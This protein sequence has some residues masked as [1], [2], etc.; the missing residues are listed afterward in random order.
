MAPSPDQALPLFAH[1]AQT[2]TDARL[3]V[4]SRVSYVGV[5]ALSPSAMPAKAVGDTD[6]LNG[7]SR[8]KRGCRRPPADF[9]AEVQVA[10]LFD[11]IDRLSSVPVDERMKSF[12]RTVD[13]LRISVTDRCNERCLYCRP[14]QYA[15]WNG[16]ADPLTD[17]ALRRIVRVAA[18]LGFRKFRLT[19]GEPLLRP[20]LVELVRAMSATPG[21][22]CI[23]I[24]TNGL[25]LPSLAG[26]LRAAGARTVNISLDALSPAV[27]RR[28]TGGPV[29]P[30]LEGIRAALAARFEFV[31]LNTVLMRGVNEPEL[32]PLIRFSSE[33]GVPLRLIELMPLTSRD[34]LSPANFLSIGEVMRCLR[35]REELIPVQ[36]ARLGHGPA[37]YYRLAKTGAVVGFIGAMTNRHFCD[38]CNKMRL[39][40]D[41]RLRPCL[42]HHEE[43]NLHEALADPNNDEPLRR[44]FQQAL[45]NKP[46]EHAFRDQYTPCRPM[47]AIGG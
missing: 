40:A 9:S 11:W 35:Q 10:S 47:T 15:G 7:Q 16:G 8:E 21:V 28:V 27:Y 12:G 22:E 38:T 6:D 46:W 33:L 14:H 5:A 1:V 32:W 42:G 31:K 30:V 19:G 39:T 3:R 18:G 34:V 29:E 23:G 41:G 13:Y 25:K 17:V 2:P 26:P 36:N 4:A 45:A 44:L 20:D 37:K 24:S 43:V